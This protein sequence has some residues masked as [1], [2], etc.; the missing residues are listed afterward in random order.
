MWWKGQQGTHNSVSSVQHTH[1]SM[2]LFMRRPLQGGGPRRL[3]QW[4]GRHG[5]E[6]W[7]GGKINALFISLSLQ[8]L[9]VRIPSKSLLFPQLQPTRPVPCTPTPSLPSLSESSYLFCSSERVSMPFI[10][11]YFYI[12][13]CERYRKVYKTYIYIYVC[14]HIN[15][16]MH[17]NM[18]V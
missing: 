16:Y 8:T 9:T 5:P 10:L 12:F 6:L 13:H 18:F 3:W 4:L 15:M 11:L 17:A 14:V 7:T 2:C 1:L